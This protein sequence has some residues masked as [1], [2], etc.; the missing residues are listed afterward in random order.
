MNHVIVAVR[1][2]VSDLPK[3]VTADALVRSRLRADGMLLVTLQT[4]AVVMTTLVTMV[5]I[6]QVMA[7]IGTT[8][9]ASAAQLAG[10]V[11]HPHHEAFMMAALVAPNGSNLT[12][13]SQKEA[14]KVCCCTVCMKVT[15]T[16]RFQFLAALYLLV[17]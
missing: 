5:E 1:M 12:I 13:Q 16:N 15:Q 3:V 14:S 9:T 10:V 8:S 6:L 11:A 17:A 4:R 7:E 2:T